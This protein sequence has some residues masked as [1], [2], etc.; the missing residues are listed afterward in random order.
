MKEE[1]DT[2]H[3]VPCLFEH[4]TSISNTNEMEYSLRKIKEAW[5]SRKDSIS[6]SMSCLMEEETASFTDATIRTKVSVFSDEKDK[7]TYFTKFKAFQCQRSFVRE[8][9]KFEP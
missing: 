3:N 5:S 8:D 1:S 9:E 7:T 2:F 4:K 6:C